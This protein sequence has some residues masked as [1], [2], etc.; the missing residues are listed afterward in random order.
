MSRDKRT[1]EMISV[2]NTPST[3]LRIDRFDGERLELDGYGLA[4]AFFVGDVMLGVNL[5]D[6]ASAARRAEI[7]GELLLHLRAQGRAN[8]PQLQA[9]ATRLNSEGIGRPLVRILD[10]IIWFSHPAAGVPGAEREIAVTVP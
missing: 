5:P 4:R 1:T 10:A 8:L 2:V 7:A 3:T 9:I 6:D